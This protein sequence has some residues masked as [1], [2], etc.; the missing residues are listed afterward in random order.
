MWAVISK[1]MKISRR[2]FAL[3]TKRTLTRDSLSAWSKMLAKVFKINVTHCQHC[4]GDLATLAAITNRSEVAR[5]FKHLGIEHEAPARAT[6]RYQEEPF[7]FG[8]EQNR[9]ET[10]ATKYV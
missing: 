6:P 2:D 8:Y 4:K 5:Y 9:Y 10:T 1:L 7:E 3:I